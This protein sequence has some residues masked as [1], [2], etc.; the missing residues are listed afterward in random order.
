MRTTK[1]STLKK[2][3]TCLGCCESTKDV[4][5]E[6][7]AEAIEFICE[8]FNCKGK[9]CGGIKRI[10]LVEDENGKLKRGVWFGADGVRNTIEIEHE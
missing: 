4:P 9:G 8:N 3:A 7:N 5:A 2:L 1:L 6:S 10:V